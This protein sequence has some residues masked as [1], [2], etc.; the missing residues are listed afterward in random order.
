M[1]LPP[2]FFLFLSPFLSSFLS[3]SLLLLFFPLSSHLPH[4]TLLFLSLPC[5]SLPFP[6]PFFPCFS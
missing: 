4:S 5:P 3:L 6:S 1:A 2:L